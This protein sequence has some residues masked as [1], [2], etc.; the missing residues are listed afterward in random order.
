[1]KY[2]IWKNYK[3]YFITF[4]IILLLLLFVGIFLYSVPVSDY[5]C[6]NIVEDAS[7]CLS[8]S[9]CRVLRW[10]NSSVFNV[11]ASR[12]DSSVILGSI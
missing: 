8:S 6:E 5:L 3:W 4:I 12:M 9:F 10:R 11:N 1:M 2:I 7:V